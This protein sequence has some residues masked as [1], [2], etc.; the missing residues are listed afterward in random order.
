MLNT[1]RRCTT[2]T[3]R[4]ERLTSLYVDF[5]AWPAKYDVE[6]CICKIDT[7]VDLTAT[8][9]AAAVDTALESRDNDDVVDDDDDNEKKRRRRKWKMEGRMQTQTQ[10]LVLVLR[11]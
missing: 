7:A 3:L 5:T 4:F 2:S 9:F 8:E 11:Q 1:L 6:N 10:V